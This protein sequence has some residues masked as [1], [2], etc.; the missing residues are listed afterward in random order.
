MENLLDFLELIYLLGQ[1]RV[2]G[3]RAG[4]LICVV[5]LC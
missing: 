3:G 4:K 2:A 1:V 5:D